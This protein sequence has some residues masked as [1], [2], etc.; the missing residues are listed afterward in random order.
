MALI[1]P[2]KGI[3]CQALKIPE[4]IIL[5]KDGRTKLFSFV[6]LKTLAPGRGSACF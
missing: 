3:S 5:K 1:W 2:A 4:Q 6:R